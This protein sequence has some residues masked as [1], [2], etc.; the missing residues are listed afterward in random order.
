M[1]IFSEDQTEVAVW[2]SLWAGGIIG[3]YFFKDTA[4]RNVNVNGVSYR[5]MISHF[6]F[7]QN[8]RTCL[9]DIWCQQDDGTCHTARV[10]LD[11]LRA[12]FGDHFISRAGLVNW[13]PRS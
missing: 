9:Y 10:K 2:C 8:A 13:P 1:S 4:N 5:E 3:P 6:F 12:Q 7:A 11:L